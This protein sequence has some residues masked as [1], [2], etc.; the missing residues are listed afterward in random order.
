M[1]TDLKY[2]ALTAM[3]TA[4]LW[5][6]YVVAQVKTNGPLQPENYI[7]PTPRP[8]PD[9]G[10]RANRTYVN[11]VETF[12][13]FAALVIVAHL[14]GKA[15]AMTAFWATCYFW[16]RLAHAAVFLLGLPLVR[17]ILFTLGYIAVAGI[18]WEV[19]K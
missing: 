5:I 2:L 14:A 19:V 16:L 9:W 1:S 6:P 15:N 13:P 18:F 12:A 10:K 4:S 7:D 3:L 17:T 8:L 11:A